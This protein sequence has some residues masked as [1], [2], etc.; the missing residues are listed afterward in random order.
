MSECLPF[1]FGNEELYA[2]VEGR[3]RDFLL[4]DEKTLY[5]TDDDGKLAWDDYE[6]D[7]PGSYEDDRPM[8]GGDSGKIT[9]MPGDGVGEA[10]VVRDGFKYDLKWWDKHLEKKFPQEDR[11]QPYLREVHLPG[12]YG[13]QRGENYDFFNDFGTFMGIVFL[14]ALVCIVFK[15]IRK[16]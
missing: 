1:N 3:H 16:R 9:R 12:R 5:P 15:L 6:Y 7:S 10:P 13:N 2:D 8:G 14:V 11:S 4:A